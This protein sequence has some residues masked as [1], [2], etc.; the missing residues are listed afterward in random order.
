MRSA[1]WRSWGFVAAAGSVS[2]VVACLLT[3]WLG[4]SPSAPAPGV[5]AVHTE[6]ESVLRRLDELGQRLDEAL[7]EVRSRAAPPSARTEVAESRPPSAPGAS[8]L[9]RLEREL[10]LLL[11]MSRAGA[12]V[13]PTLLRA[14]PVQHAELAALAALE[15]QDAVAANRSTMLLT[16]AEV[17]ARFGFPDDAG[18]SRDAGSYWKYTHR[19]ATGA[20]KGGVTLYFRD[21]RVAWQEINI[22]D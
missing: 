8:Q 14:Q 17:V 10:A 9:D 12:G 7:A 1:D 18:P 5:G 2:G 16:P 15:R 13:E 6:H 21:G 11:Q 3:T 19:D 4:T 22:P 20:A